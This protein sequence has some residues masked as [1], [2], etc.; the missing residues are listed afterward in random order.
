M[1]AYEYR[2]LDAQGRKKRGV[3][4][5]DSARQ[6]RSRLKEQGLIPLEVTETLA[7]AEK[8]RKAASSAGL[9]RFTARRGLSTPALALITRQLST[10]VKSGMPLEQCLKAVAEQSE[11]KRIRLMLM[12]VRARVLE[13][14]SLA[15]GLAEY[16]H[17]FNELF[18]TM[19]AAGEK[20][21]HLDAIL[22]RLADYSEN[23]QKIRSKLQ[24]AMIYPIVLVVFAVCIVAF[25]LAS[26]V[27]KIIGQFMEMGQALPWSTQLL[28]DSSAFVQH[29]GLLIFF[30]FLADIYLWR[31][32]LSRPA[33][34]LAW[35]KRVMGFP[36]VG[37][38]AR[39]LNT[40]R[41]ARTLAICSSSAI[42]ILDGMR[43]AADVIVNPYVKQ[44]VLQAA[45]NVREGSSLGRALEQARLFP[46]MMLH[47]VV[48]GEQSG[49]LESMLTR[50]ADNQDE[51]FESTINIAL[52]IFTPALI[53]VMA[54]MVLFIV[55]A[56]LMPILEM[57]NL[58][59]Q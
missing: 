2:A 7:K 36:L 35:S 56:T 26:V 23:R 9:S 33:F 58:L 13:G 24:Q 57:N 38:V 14:Y 19:V 41:F 53:A 31:W 11:K 54:G 30:F 18:R 39:G 52:G 44:Q 49:D 34:H 10:M 37:K 32:L 5:G 3:I 42:P 50:A 40:S 29:W 59:T 21:G 20:S 4:E 45:D 27:P 43:V 48:S 15:E 25:L 12:T 55:M 1:A 16:P 8:S 46:P 17:C 47:M 6:V 28:L 51:T 22:S